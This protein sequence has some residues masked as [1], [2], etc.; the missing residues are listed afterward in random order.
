MAYKGSRNPAGWCATSANDPL[1]R[2]SERLTQLIR[3][4]ES[5]T[6]AKAIK[7]G[8]ADLASRDEQREVKYHA[9]DG[10]SINILSGPNGDPARYTGLLAALGN[11]AFK[12]VIFEGKAPS[13]AVLKF[14]NDLAKLYSAD[15]TPIVFRDMERSPA[16]NQLHGLRFS[17]DETPPYTLT[18]EDS[19]GPDGA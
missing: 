11:G 14:C 7:A 5:K 8:V 2:D 16:R 9:L 13:P 12:E 15:G 19:S 1:R 6:G 18:A 4:L 10:L 17:L 3:A